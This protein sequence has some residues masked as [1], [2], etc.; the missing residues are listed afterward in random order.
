MNELDAL[1]RQPIVENNPTLS[2][3][4]VYLQQPQPGPNGP[5][6]DMATIQSYLSKAGEIYPQLPAINGPAFMAAMDAAPA[7]LNVQDQRNVRDR[8]RSPMQVAR[9]F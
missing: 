8:G 2:A 1:A 6:P 9:Q 5:M 4:K 7:S 3:L